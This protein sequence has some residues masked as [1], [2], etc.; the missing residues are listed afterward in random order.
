MMIIGNGYYTPKYPLS[1]I[2]NVGLLNKKMNKREY[3]I[4]FFCSLFLVG[5][6]DKFAT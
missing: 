5:N 2:N 4:I 6:T 1:I 3:I